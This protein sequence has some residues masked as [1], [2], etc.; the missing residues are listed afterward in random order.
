M[1]L[2]GIYTGKRRIFNDIPGNLPFIRKVWLWG[3]ILGV[4]GNLLYVYFGHL[5]S[6]SIPSPQLL[7]SLTGQTFGAP[8]LAFFYMATLT[9]L[10]ERPVWRRRLAPLSYVGRMALTNYLAQSLIC[11]TLFYGYGFGLYDK[12]GIAAGIV[13]T[14]AIYAMADRLEHL[15]AAPL[16]VRADGMALAHIDLRSTAAN[17]RGPRIGSQTISHKEAS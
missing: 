8:A 1:M 15:V 17:G 5:S 13:L 6:R 7:I 14:L 10:A 3:L 4:I 12:I 11:T 2:L 16:P 9:L